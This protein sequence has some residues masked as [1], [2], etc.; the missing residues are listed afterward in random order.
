MSKFI[1]FS[2]KQKSTMQ[3]MLAF[4]AWMMFSLNANAQFVN[5][6]VTGFNNDI[7][8]NGVGAT[9]TPTSGAMPGV[10]YPA[11]GVDGGGFSF[12]DATYQYH[13]GSTLPACYLPTG[14][15]I[16]SVLSSGLTYQLQSYSANNAL[17][18]A[19]NTYSGSVHPTSGT[20]SLVTPSSYGN[21][22]V[23]YESVMNT[24]VPTT[25]TVTATVT[26]TDATTQVISSISVTNWFNNVS[27]AYALPISRANNNAPGN[28][29]GCGA[30]AGPY[31]F[32][33][34]LAISPA[35]YSKSVQSISFNWSTAIGT[36]A[37]TLDYLH[38]LAV[39]G[40][41][42]CVVP[43]N[44]PTAL[45]LT[46]ISPSQINGSFAAAAPAPSG[47]LV[48]RYPAGASV[49]NPNNGTTYTV[50]Q[51][52]G[53]PSGLGTVVSVGSSTSLTSTGLTSGTAYDYYIYAYNNTS[54]V[55]GPAYNLNIISGQNSGSQTTNACGSM[56]PVITVGPTGNY[57]SLSGAPGVLAAIEANGISAPTVIE[58]QNNYIAT[59]I[60]TYPIT[61]NYSGCFSVSN[62]LNIR[63]E[64]S[65]TSP[66]TISS[67]NT[68]ATFDLNGAR[69]VTIDGRP[70]GVSSNKM[71]V[72][73]NTSSVANSSGNAILLRNDASSNIIRNLEVRAANV[74]PAA[75]GAMIA[76][77][78]TPGAIA[79][80]TTNKTSGNDDNLITECDIHSVS[81]SGN[82]NVGIYAANNFGAGSPQNNDNL[83]ISNCNVYDFFN[84][85]TASAGI[86]IGVGSNNFTIIDN[87][88]YQT[89]S[90]IITS[91]PVVR[92]MWITPNINTT[93]V[94]SAS[95]FVVSGNFIGG[96]NS[97]GT[98]GAYTFLGSSFYTFTA[99]DLNFGVGT[100]SSV[101]N[102]TITNLDLTGAFALNSV[103]MMDIANGNVNVGTVTGNL[104]GSTTQN[105]AIKVTTSANSNNNLFVGF[106]SGGGN[107]INFS[108]NTISGIDVYGTLSNIATGFTLIANSGGSN[109]T[110][111]N[112]TI[113]SS[114]I[115]NSVS[116]V[117]ASGSAG[118]AF[119]SRGI[120]VNSSTTGAVCTVTNNTITNINSNSIAGGGLASSLIGIAVTSTSCSVTGNM[121]SNLTSAGRTTTSGGTCALMGIAFSSPTAP[122]TISGNTIHSLKLT[123]DTTIAA[124][125]VCGLYYTTPGASNLIERNFIHSL[126]IASPTNS[127]GTLTGIN[128]DGGQAS[129]QNNMIGLGLN[130]A[131]ANIIS[132]FTIVGIRKGST[133]TNLWFN[134]IYIGGTNVGTTANNTYAL[135][136]I[137]N[138]NDD[139]RNNV[140]V[141]N[142]SNATTGGKHYAINLNSTATLNLNYNDY[143]GTGTGYVFG[144]VGATNYP[145]Y[146][147]SWVPGDANSYALDPVFVNPDGNSS[148]VNLHISNSAPS[149]VESTGIAIASV[150]NDIDNDVRAGFTPTDI[151]ADAGNFSGLV[152]NGTPIG[153][154]T[155][156]TQTGALCVS[157]TKT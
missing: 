28:P 117:S 157:G 121:I 10:T 73:E 63:P 58:L 147:S 39:G 105:G 141:N 9:N 135:I 78:A 140:F 50:G 11:I 18:I 110:I 129:V 75:S 41:A 84:P 137:S 72:I 48:V 97:S 123:N 109:V 83:T 106:R 5:I 61:I 88:L 91:T 3:V 49:T 143:F 131:G 148:N 82:M 154:I 128:L 35:N 79:I 20:M 38:V 52:V 86:N 152:C 27:R 15:A 68:T 25:P 47:Y 100:A 70:G 59:G 133:I 108:N 112:N 145:N 114:A 156:I 81:S 74:N 43:I 76:V 138:A 31:L 62:T 60:E 115:T 111:N 6:P 120:L 21:L 142:R 71:L 8:A 13:S 136:R 23:L 87:H 144:A 29:D 118:T 116:A 7:V 103:R 51:I 95:G 65:T 1:Y 55:G 56:P 54:C 126:S 45:T 149:I 14:G 127:A 93:A 12:I 24:T 67:S 40:M 134:S 37:N 102:N 146:L 98:G 34:T 2:K 94:S 57:P 46:S 132:P 155:A 99:M 130:D 16:P 101:Q 17:T 19:S 89:V 107:I 96:R 69:Y 125:Q 53:L 77:G 32:Q 30:T 36:T 44:Q 92:A 90:R 80:T 104:I 22:Y 4:I 119:G 153:G 26:F 42:P 66:R 122:A 150:S 139:I 64:A 124:V 33:M 113:G 85:G 151:G